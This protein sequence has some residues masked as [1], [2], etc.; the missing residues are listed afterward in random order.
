M[1]IAVLGWGSLIWNP[2]ILDIDPEWRKDGPVLPIEFARVS[3]GDRLTLVIGEGFSRQ[4]T[5]WTLSRKSTLAD[6]ANNLQERERCPNSVAIGK[7][8][9]TEPGGTEEGSVLSSIK[10]WAIDRGLEGVVW[11][12]LGPKRPNGKNGLASD[13]E[14]LAYLK[15]LVA[16]GRSSA[17]R[18]YFKK[19]PP[20]I[21][22]PLRQRI[23]AELGWK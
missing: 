5:L 4:T 2:G 14:L 20:Q 12:A 18:E 17:A 7:W 21:E 16:E 8:S 1:K 6:A 13:D 3:G 23:R 15:T 22:T 10:H 19:A 11:T 9:S